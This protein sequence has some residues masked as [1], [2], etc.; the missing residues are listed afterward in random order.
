MPGPRF[1]LLVTVIVVL[2]SMLRRVSG[3]RAAALG[4]SF[5]VATPQRGSST[6]HASASATVAPENPLLVKRGGLP[7]FKEIKAEHVTPAIDT[8]LKQLKDDFEQLERALINPQQGESWGNR[9]IEYD[10]PGVVEKLE[11]IQG[12]LGFSWGVVN[13]LMGVSNSDELRSAHQKL[14]PSVVQTYQSLGQSQPLF[15]ALTAIKSR[16][17]V[18]SS[19]DEAQR[20]IVTSSIR[21]ME[22]S[23]VGLPLEQREQFNKLQLEAAELSTKFSNNVLD[24]TKAFKLKITDPAKLS[25]VPESALAMFAQK[26][27][28]EGDKDATAAAG[29]WVVTLDLPAYMPI[30][31]HAKDRDLR[32]QLY[33]SY[34]T[35]ASSGEHDNA[36]LI[37]RIL[38][39]KREMAG[40]LG[41]KSHAEKSLSNKM[42]GSVAA[43]DGLTA[44]LLEASYPAAQRDLEQVRAFA[45]AEGFSD[46]L[47]LWDVTFWSERLREKEYEFSEEELKPY[48][49]LPAVLDGLFKLCARIFAVRIEAADGEA[50]VWHEDVRFF[51]IYD[52]TSNE[53]I[54][55]FFLD[56]YSRPATKRG[57][58]W[59]DS[60]TGRS[61]AL[62]TKPV[63][64][65]TC[66]GSPP[67]GDT[68]SLMTF[69]EVTTLFHETGHGL[70]HMLT[71]VE[72]GD[73]AGISNVEWDCVELPSQFMENWCFDEH[74]LYSFAKHYKTGE[75]LPKALFDKVV[76][77]KNFQSG[78]QMIRQLFFGSMD[79][80][81]HSENFDP[82][83]QSIFDAQHE[84]AKKYTVI[85]PLPEDRFLCSFGHI[86]AGGYSAGYYRFVA[87]HHSKF[88]SF[89][90]LFPI[91]TLF[92]QPFSRTPRSYKWAEV[93]SA[94][95][96]AAFEEEGLDNEEKIKAKGLLFR[97]TV[98][99]MGGGKHPSDVFKA[100]RGR[101]PSPEALLR[102]NGLAAAKK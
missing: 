9:R 70:Q 13:H 40:I 29:P 84:L 56:P 3:L 57:G 98:L 101:D 27:V 59:M 21:G 96:F 10:Y 33:R 32:E 64:Y 11:K 22:N 35:R 61:K 37:K 63:A 38:E 94:D 31:Q 49:P 26:A 19:L 95:A 28:Q 90:L 66:N 48:F 20:R 81:L 17:S 41:F 86:F 93:L 16:Q 8:S 92:P 54:A 75:P 15:K 12:P 14:Q 25:G 18:W 89:S 102:H 100:F 97:N 46:E 44:M 30:M 36:P 51:K 67:V 1:V 73:A 34:V 72:H 6:A 82:S 23:G 53:H 2:F 24:S 87:S 78:M 71:T 52:E 45:K 65:L 50:Q 4:L 76:A 91:L 74:T 80:F 83:T 60:A 5:S 39:I 42:A 69:R 77:A 43:V 47:K 62:G 79:L 55:S 68:P 99:S 7:L 88:L 58:A 85:P